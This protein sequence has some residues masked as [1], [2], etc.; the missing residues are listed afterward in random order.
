MN[1]LQELQELCKRGLQPLDRMIWLGV[2]FLPQ[3]FN[4]IEIDPDYL[5]TDEQCLAV[6]G[7][8]VL[9]LIKGYR[10]NWGVVRR[11]CGALYQARP[12]C[13]QLYDLDYR[14]VAFLKLGGQQCLKS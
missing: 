11:L 4:A 12:R 6:S 3:K 13:L 9:V 14:K 5:P 1:P 2:G 7:L 8:D 10:T